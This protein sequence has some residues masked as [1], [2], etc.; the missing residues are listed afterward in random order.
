MLAR[1]LLDPEAPSG[2]PGALPDAVVTS[3]AHD[4][5]ARA[6]AA[7]SCVLLK[8]EGGALPLALPLADAATGTAF[9]G[10]D[11]VKTTTGGHGGPTLAL[12][13]D[14]AAAGT[15]S[16]GGGSGAVAARHVVSLLEGIYRRFGLTEEDWDGASTGGNCTV[17]KGVDYYQ[18]HLTR[19]RLASRPCYQIV[20]FLLFVPFPFALN[21][22]WS[23]LAAVILLL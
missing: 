22:L 3:P 10:R 15:I 9:S 2:A 23:F 4:A 6:L 5:A 17:E 8:N 13:G 19:D 11:G 7:R 12:L 18:V 1:G 14:A 16:G 21:S 20:L